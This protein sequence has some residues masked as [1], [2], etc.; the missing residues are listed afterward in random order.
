MAVQTATATGHLPTIYFLL[1][2]SLVFSLNER[3]VAAIP[4]QAA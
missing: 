4:V 1:I 2:S 3:G